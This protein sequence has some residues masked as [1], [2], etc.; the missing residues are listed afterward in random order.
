MKR[1][2]I[3]YDKDGNYDYK[4]DL[5]QRGYFF[6]PTT[7]EWY[8]NFP[9][10]LV[11][12]YCGKDSDRKWSI[13]VIGEDDFAMSWSGETRM[14]ALEMLRSLPEIIT[15]SDLKSRGFTND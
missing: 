2:K 7:D 4:A 15:K 12:I 11:A 1:Y 9:G 3:P 14:Q 10:N 6:R 13:S 8:P 5:T